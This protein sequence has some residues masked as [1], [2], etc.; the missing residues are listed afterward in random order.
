MFTGKTDF[1]QIYLLLILNKHLHQG[2]GSSPNFASKIK[3]I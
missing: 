1:I 2:K 3:Q